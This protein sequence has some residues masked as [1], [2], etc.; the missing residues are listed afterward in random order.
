MARIRRPKKID[1]SEYTFGGS[2]AAASAAAVGGFVKIAKGDENISNTNHDGFIANGSTITV[3][4]DAG[5]SIPTKDQY[6]YFDNSFDTSTGTF[7]YE[8][9]NGDTALPSGVNFQ[10]N[11]DDQNADVGFARFYG[12]PN[13]V[14][15]N[16][17]KIKGSYAKGSPAEQIELTYVLR[18]LPAG[19]TPVWDQTP[20]AF[21]SRFIRNTAEEVT[22]IAGP[23]TV[24]SGATY[25]LSNVSGFAAGVTP[26]IES[27]TG[28]VYLA[29][30]GDIQAAATTHSLT[31]NADLGEYGVVS[32]T[33][34]GSVPYGDAYGSRYF[35]PA[36]ARGNV[37]G[38][39]SYTLSESDYY[40]NPLKNSGALRRVW[41][42]QEDTSPYLVDDG[43][44]CAGD[45]N[46]NPSTSTYDNMSGYNK[47]GLMGIYPGATIFA[48]GSNHQSVT[49]YW[50]VPAGVTSICAVVVGA[51]SMGAY[52]WAEE[53]GGGGGL[54]WMNGIS[55]TP[56]EV[57]Q[58]CWGLGRAVEYN[59]GSYGAGS[60]WLKR[61][62]G[63]PNTNHI[64]FGQGGG[65]TGYASSSPEGQS[66][67]YTGGNVTVSG[68]NYWD[69]GS[70]Y[71]T[72]QQRDGGGYGVNTSEGSAVSD[73]DGNTFHYGGGAAY[74]TTDRTGTGAA[75]YRGNQANGAQ[76]QPGYYG[77][78]GNGYDYSSTH[79]Y[80][81]GGGVGLDGQGWRGHHTDATPRSSNNAGSGYAGN[82]GSWTSYNFGSPSF[83]GGGGG[84]S[85]GTRGAW[86]ENQFTGSAE[87][88]NGN[89]H[90]VGGM[91]GGGG[92]GSGTSS[93]GGHGAPGGVRI[94]WGIGADGTARSFPYTYCSENPNMKY[95][96]EA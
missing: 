70:G 35:G 67:S 66:S 71:G 1:G 39:Q 54:A 92:G 51:G 50:T 20:N 63:G 10:E 53:G 62:S 32:Q 68:I 96:G 77:G 44:G 37:Q 27:D 25:T 22:I 57:L 12:T 87:N 29:S 48:S 15:T 88:G 33:F 8:L 73:G 38:G 78:G 30:I 65:Y 31:V 18:V 94:I 6:L 56:G 83:Y 45:N 55:V 21:P 7:T 34:T 89:G 90:R 64:I 59:N 5:T 60:S 95:N 52:Q 2:G 42:A 81:A 43:Y 49:G 9:T 3:T 46:Y 40:H 36:N 13:T 80:G 11:D 41:N 23:T 58:W 14:G 47:N 69:K 28:R 84:G 74:Y 61:H 82:G 93:G 72:N 75:G 85:G 24:Y 26:I 76:N 19:T 4:V 16:T 79:G 17:F 86:G 91:H